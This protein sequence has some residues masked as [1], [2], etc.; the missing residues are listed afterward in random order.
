[1]SKEIFKEGIKLLKTLKSTKM[2]LKE[3]SIYLETVDGEIIDVDL[4]YDVYGEL[5]RS[6]SAFDN[7]EDYEEHL[8]SEDESVSEEVPL[9]N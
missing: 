3:M 5:R 1:M 6:F 2:P 9:L 4:E 7:E 8:K